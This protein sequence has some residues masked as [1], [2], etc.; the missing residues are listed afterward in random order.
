MR[1][2]RAATA[3]ITQGPVVI[4]SVM[5]YEISLKIMFDEGFTSL[6]TFAAISMISHTDLIL[7]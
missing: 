1:V 2:S 5:V 4:K 3:F 7:G 6:F